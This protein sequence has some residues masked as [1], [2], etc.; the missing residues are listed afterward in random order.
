VE[1]DRVVV[2]GAGMAGLATS[3]LLARDGHDVVVIERDAFALGEVNDA[4][5]WPRKG[6]PHFLQPH[7]FMPRGRKELAERLPDVLD[8]LM[9]AGANDVDMRPKL[10]GPLRPE[11]VDLQYLAVRRPVIEWALRRAVVAQAGIEVRSGC[12]ATGLT[13]EGRRVTGVIA[14]GDQVATSLVV[15][16]LGRR[17][18][19]RE[20]LAEQGVDEDPPESSDCGVVYYSRY[21]RLRE[22]RELPDG[23]W[24]LGPRG[25]LGY[26]GFTTFPGDNRTFAALLAVPPGR[27]SARALREPAVFEAALASIPAITTW[28]DPERIDPITDVF[29][30]AG[31][32]N[33]IRNDASAGVTGLIP[34]GDAACHTDP[35]LAIGL[36]FSL[37]HAGA[38][39]DAL[40]ASD[41]I[42]GATNRFRAATT[43]DMRERFEF[44]TRLDEQR[45]RMWNGGTVD[46]AS[47][48]GDYELFTIV[49]GGAVT[50]VDPDVFRVVVRRNGLLTS[51]SLLDG[52][53]AMLDRIETSFKA[54][55]AAPRPASGPT[56]NEMTELIAATSSDPGHG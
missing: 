33:S 32:R 56:R 39:V 9:Q 7:A 48:N 11:D 10:P 30:M 21:Y 44:A 28:V 52:D 16:A 49:A 6:I 43:P 55:S 4:P 45:L 8:D 18:R 35:V 22:G 23:P 17:M 19:T 3:L 29:T 47:K 26:L 20:W 41:T 31:L 34:V 14:G 24:L 25:D 38:L 37:V 42:D 51:G 36:S 50:L 5:A 27:P 46:F 54:M 13:M 40:R 15:D 12:E 2:L 53:A 1:L